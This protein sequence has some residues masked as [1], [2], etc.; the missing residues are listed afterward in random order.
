LTEVSSNQTIPSV[1]SAAYTR[2]NLT[3]NTDKL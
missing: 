2:T 3:I 1:K